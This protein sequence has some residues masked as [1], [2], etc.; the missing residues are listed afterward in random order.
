MSTNV[1][2]EPKNGRTI[3]FI[4]G[5]FSNSTTAWQNPN[6]TY[7]PSLVKDD[8]NF[9]GWGIVCF[10][11][12]ASFGSGDYSLSD[13]EGSLEQELGSRLIDLQPE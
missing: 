7:W 6:G 4:H 3:V 9:E 2:R 5:L 13:V 12:D 8:P 11:Y 10:E 1:I